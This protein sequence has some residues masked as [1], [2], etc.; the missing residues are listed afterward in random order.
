MHK[1][2]LIEDR[3]CG[4]KKKRN[5]LDTNRDGMIPLFLIQYQATPTQHCMS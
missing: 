3:S 5:S 4:T 2:V 1:H